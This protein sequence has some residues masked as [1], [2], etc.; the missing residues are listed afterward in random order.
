MKITTYG[1]DG[2]PNGYLVPIWNALEQPDQRPDQVYLTAVA[3]GAQK[4]PHLH[5]IRCGRF[6]CI[7][8]DVRIVT[9][10]PDGAYQ[11]SFSGES[12]HFRKIHVAPG[13]AACI[14]NDSD[15]EAL[16]LNMP[17]PAWSSECPDECPVED[18]TA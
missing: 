7:K 18:W 8:G 12:Y 5:K 3:P 1:S 9:R 17:T 6:I 2:Q 11:T 4:G 16:V 15:A 13:V 10:T 14:Y